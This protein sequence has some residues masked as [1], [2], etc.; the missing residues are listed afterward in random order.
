[1]IWFSL[2]SLIPVGH[3][4]WWLYSR[5]RPGWPWYLCLSPN[6]SKHVLTFFLTSWFTVYWNEMP[7]LLSSLS[8]LRPTSERHR[9]GNKAS[10]MRCWKKLKDFDVDL[11]TV[12]V[13]SWGLVC[14]EV[15]HQLRDMILATRKQIQHLLVNVSA[16]AIKGSYNIQTSRNRHPDWCHPFP[17]F[18]LCYCCM[19]R[20]SA[21]KQIYLSV[22]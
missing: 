4:W 3:T 22:C 2:S 14:L 12:E 17:F 18:L 15:F 8:H 7:S 19:L 1:M 16:A 5:F 10:T 21:E 9:R 6:S 11:I 20:F 13:G